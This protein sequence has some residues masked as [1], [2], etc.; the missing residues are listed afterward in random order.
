MESLPKTNSR[1]MVKTTLRLS[2]EA[3]EKL[4]WLAP[5]EGRSR[6]NLIIK[7]LREGLAR[8]RRQTEGAKP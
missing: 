6:N 2:D 1:G 3:I 4:S 7:I 8:R 5:I